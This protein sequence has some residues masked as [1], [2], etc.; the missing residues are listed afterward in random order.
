MNKH[1]LAQ[2]IAKEAELTNVQ[3]T[4]AVNAITEGIQK[5]LKKGNDVTLVG[6]GTFKVVKR[7]ARVGINPQTKEKMKI[8]ARK[9]VKFVAGKGL[10]TAV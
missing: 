8:P 10:K 1:E 7:K 6:F 2:L 5:A 9:A 4:A 3:A